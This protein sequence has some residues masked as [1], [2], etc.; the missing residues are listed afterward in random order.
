[1]QTK[2]APTTQTT[3]SDYIATGIARIDADIRTLIDSLRGILVDLGEPDTAAALPWRTGDSPALD[4]RPSTLDP[5]TAT[6]QAYS[7]AFQLLNMVEENAAGR[8]RRLREQSDDAA[9]NRGTWPYYLARLKE[10]GFTG[11]AIAEFLP[12]VRVEPV[13]TAHPTESKRPAVLAQHRVLHGLLEK[14]DNAALSKSERARLHETLEVALERLWRSGEILLDKPQIAAERTGILFHL[15]E[16]FPRSLPVVDQRLIDAWDAA[17][18]DR[19]LLA[20]PH[21]W[22]RLRFGTWVGGDRDGHALV[23]A[24]VTRET[25]Q[26]LRRNALVVLDQDLRDLADALPLSSSVQAP[27]ANLT[28]RIDEYTTLLGPRAD[29]IATQQPDEPWRQFV[30][31]LRARLPLADHRDTNAEL[32]DAPHAYRHAHELDGDLTLLHDSLTAIGAHRLD[33]ASVWPVRRAV[34]VFG[35]HLA[36]LDVRQNSTFHDKA[37]GQILAAADLPG[38][39]FA[40]WT[41]D[42][43]LEFLTAEL[44]SPR[45]FLYGDTGIGTEADAVLACYGTLRCHLRDYG[46]KGI[47]SLIISMTRSL[48]DLLV[49]YVLAREAGLTQWID[50]TLVCEFPVVPLFETQD[51][52]RRSPDLMRAFL[53]H[54][55][56]K[57]SIEHHRTQSRT[58]TRP[59][60]QVMIGYSDSNKDCGILASQWTLYRAQRELTAAGDDSGVQ[61]RFFHGRGGTISRGAGPTHRFL[62]ALPDGTI[63]ADFRLTEQGETIAQ[64]YGTVPIAA[65]NLEL[66]VGGVTAVSLEQAGGKIPP[67]PEV[68]AIWTILDRASTKTYQDFIH[69]E[70]FID[71]YSH[72]TPIDALENTRIGSRPARRTG[73]RSLADLR[74]I[75]WVFSWNQSRT[76]LPGW[77]GVGSGLQA[78]ANEKPDLFAKVR[79]DIRSRPVLYYVLTNVETNVASADPAIMTEYAAL[80]PDEKIR[81][82]FLGRIQAE[83]DLTKKMLDEIF[84]GA[85]EKRRPRMIKTLELRADALLVLHRRQIELL[86]EWRN[87][88]GES[89]NEILPRV[90][91]SINAIASGL[92]TTG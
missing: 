35:F 33:A 68:D 27:S 15:R 19:Q 61:I 23:T 2:E 83:F 45:P 12:H 51:D 25:L 14:I 78:L 72:A 8:T 55:V 17:G 40:D 89:A 16:V 43:R 10:G 66:L 56:T 62:D 90:L 53:A 49:V 30:H 36:A 5:S 21:T 32:L 77:F 64:K 20:N 92:R 69:A 4:P 9:R 37:L 57:A 18:F 13:L 67:R 58:A 50:G 73:K 42:Q 29:V 38:T 3:T 41:E 81:D 59:V 79:E 82:H 75:P 91:L 63:Q 47:G 76:Y 34:D 74:A 44:Q 46:P 39:D 48:S 6:E 24:D 31:L 85:V 11:E 87:A 84:Q 1:M 71:F 65:H 80:V 54:P 70:G 60:Q 52:L 7:I 86:K 22:P 28:A 26:E 88:E